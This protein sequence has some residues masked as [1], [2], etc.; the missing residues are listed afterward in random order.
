MGSGGEA[1]VSLP[2]DILVLFWPQGT[3]LVTPLGWYLFTY[4]I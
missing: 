3:R 4:T 2:V 1:A